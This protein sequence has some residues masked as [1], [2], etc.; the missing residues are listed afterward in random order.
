MSYEDGVVLVWDPPSNPNGDIYHYE[1][2]WN[3]NNQTHKQNVTQCKFKFPGVTEKDRFVV[4]VRAFGAAGLGI[5]LIIDPDKWKILPPSINGPHKQAGGANILDS[6]MILAIIFISFMLVALIVGYFL[7]RRH[8]YCKTSNGIINSD[9]SSFPPTTSPITEAIHTQEMYEMQTLIPTNQ[10]VL[11][12]GIG[13]A[14]KSESP[15]NGVV[16]VNESQKILRTSTPTDDSIDRMCIE[17]PPIKCN[18][19]SR[20]RHDEPFNA[21]FSSTS[22]QKD[23][24]NGA[25]KVNG[26]S[27]PFKSFQVS[28]SIS[29]CLLIGVDE[30][31]FDIMK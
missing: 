31:I 25:L 24:R 29:R 8:R 26:N 14:N 4:T 9:Q 17:L 23:F 13:L 7:C 15:C 27:S 21:N 16:N 2:E 1:V 18:E 5:P 28:Y 3:F 11:I 6:F 22:E 30:M 10:A 20:I 19:S 12:N